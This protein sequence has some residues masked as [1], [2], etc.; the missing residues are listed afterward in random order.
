MCNVDQTSRGAS[1]QSC[2]L[3]CQ[4][5]YQVKNRS[6]R[7]RRIH[8]EGSARLELAAGSEADFGYQGNDVLLAYGQETLIEIEPGFV[9]RMAQLAPIQA[10]TLNRRRARGIGNAV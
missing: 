2:W 3:V 9:F 10:G 7:E 6:F 4:V 1:H 8:R 5:G